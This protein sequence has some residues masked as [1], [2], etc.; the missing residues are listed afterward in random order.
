MK[1]IYCKDI[2]NTN[3]DMSLLTHVVIKGLV[4][5]ID[6]NRRGNE[7]MHCGVGGKGV[8]VFLFLSLIIIAYSVSLTRHS[9]ERARS[10]AWVIP[11]DPGSA[12]NPTLH[13]TEKGAVPHWSELRSAQ[14]QHCLWSRPSHIT[15]AHALTHTVM[16]LY[17]TCYQAILSL[18]RKTLLV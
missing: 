4:L 13:C 8:C 1:L 14:S 5:V 6:R 12:F 9:A 18:Y 2:E 15:H 3:S 17:Y 7:Q 16:W 11:A 10:T